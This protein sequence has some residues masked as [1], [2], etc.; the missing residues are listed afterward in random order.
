MIKVF[1]SERA[2]K[3]LINQYRWYLD[4][5]SA[6]VAERFLVSFDSTI[7]R[8]SHSPQLGRWRRFRLAN[9]PASDRLR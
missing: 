9:W 2:E 8:L 5:A 6:D 4:N 1:I 3:D 7:A